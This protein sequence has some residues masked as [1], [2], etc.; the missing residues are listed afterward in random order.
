MKKQ[1]KLFALIILAV[2]LLTSC[3]YEPIYYGIMHDVLPEEATVN[4]N[5]TSIA[6]CNVGS[7][8]ASDEYLFLSGGGALKYKP[9]SSSKHGDWKSVSNL[10]FKL[11]RYN[12]FPSS[13]NPE[14]HIGQQILRV[15]S[16]KDYL[17]LLSASYTTDTEYGI[18]LPEKFY[19]WACPL[20]K[21]LTAKSSD[22]TNISKGKEA[23][24]FITK[25]NSE[26]GLFETY[27]SFFMT[28][29]PM[30]E[31]RKAFFVKYPSSAEPKYYEF[32]GT[33]LKEVSSLD[34]LG[35]YVA[36]TEGNTRANSAFYIGSNLYF[37]DSQVVTT[38]ET[39]S[40]PAT[41]ACLA[42]VSKSYYSNKE[43]YTFDGT[44][45]PEELLKTDTSISSLAFTADS[46]LIGKGSY[47]SSYTSNGGID[48]AI[49]E[50]GKP[51]NKLSDFE[52]N[53]K[54]QFTSAYILMCMLCADPSKNEADAS[55]YATVTFRGT[56]SAS[57]ASFDNIGL[58]SYYPTRGNWNRE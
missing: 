43:L 47:T 56:S 26:Q 23:E 24:Y 21:V 36:L 40:A 31:H 13:S 27:F 35:T 38:N 3:G 11:H 15:I 6:R 18:V 53:A 28:N 12:Y 41:L 55:I 17:Y 45:A 22:W 7:G 10:P 9:L 30:P 57:A 20:S 32:A 1:I 14:G 8:A 37:S 51:Q 25:Y 4:G 16:D 54:Y 58:W 39:I 52:N 50:D 19:L 48:R 49:L 44:T 34:S 33:E 2:S 29:S 46:L 42:G 5:I